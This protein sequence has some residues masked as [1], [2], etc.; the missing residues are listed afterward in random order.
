MHASTESLLSYRDAEPLA[1]PTRE[2]IDC[3]P[4]CQATLRSMRTLQASLRQLP[5]NAARPQFDPN[6][7]ISA[8]GARPTP[9]LNWAGGVAASLVVA[10][11]AVFLLQEPPRGG[12][13]STISQGAGNQTPAGQAAPKASATGAHTLE[14]LVLRS[15]QLEETLRRL[16]ARPALARA[17]GASTE[18]AL[19]SQLEMIDFGLSEAGQ[20]LSAKQQQQLWRGRVALMD[21]LVNLR[22]AQ[23]RRASL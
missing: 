4:Q 10:F 22:Y 23:F 19:V 11:A 14:Q 16:P 20:S 3:C 18:A 6:L 13:E 5:Q 9:W 1:A 21:S 15:N 7:V 12:S 17:R 2:H 8:T